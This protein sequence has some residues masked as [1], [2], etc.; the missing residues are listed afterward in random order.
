MPGGGRRHGTLR[1][2]SRGG[3]VFGRFGVQFLCLVL[4]W[5]LIDSFS[6]VSLEVRVE[7][8]THIYTHNMHLISPLDLFLLLFSCTLIW[9][10]RIMETVCR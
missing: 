8:H 7:G 1:S 3:R 10:V 5:F 6:V 4:V 2:T 9:C